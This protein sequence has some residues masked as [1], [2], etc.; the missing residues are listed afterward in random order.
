[1][2][3]SSSP[4]PRKSSP[5]F[6]LAGLT[7]WQLARGLARRILA[8]DLLGRSSQLSF[9][10]LLAIF[11]LMLFM[12][13]LFGLFASHQ[14]G[15]QDSMMRY[16]AHFLPRSAFRL[17]RDVTREL[18]ENADSGKL[19]VSILVA[20]WF[21][22][23]GVS[24]TISALNTAY[25][26]RDRRSWLK[27]RAVAIALTLSISLL[28]LFSMGV[29]L[30]GDHFAHWAGAVLRLEP[31]VVDLWALL[32]W[33][34]A[35]VFVATSF[36]MIYYYGPDLEHRH[37]RWISPGSVFGALVWFAVSLGFRFY[38]HFFNTYSAIYGS[39]GALM[40]LLFW[41]YA[42]SLA[43]LIGGEMNA[44]IESAAHDR[45]RGKAAV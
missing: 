35:V 40:I 26:A 23:S 13:T 43:F 30:L 27:V 19:G 16:L 39:L 12:L 29:V 11:P 2:P 17:L 10:F 45:H 14:A 22:S 18:V 31:V 25:R 5:L 3:R 7:F 33:P 1:M 34:L 9:D 20:L 42:S 8:D 6:N 4:T 15:L 41:L 44:E 32:E 24:A 36:S 28:V 21:S 38:L 37:W